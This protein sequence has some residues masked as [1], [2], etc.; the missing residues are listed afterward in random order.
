MNSDKIHNNRSGIERRMFSYSY[1]I[2]ERRSAHDRR[3]L[4]SYSKNWISAMSKD[5][6]G[7]LY[8]KDSVIELYGD[9]LS[10]AAYPRS[11]LDSGRILTNSE[12]R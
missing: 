10:I 7:E 6:S 3:E 5:K 2:P 8:Y 9:Y 12:H 4:N 1:H 11:L